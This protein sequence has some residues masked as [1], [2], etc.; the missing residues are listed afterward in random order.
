MPQRSA[1]LWREI[2][3]AQR[4]TPEKIERVVTWA[5]RNQEPYPQGRI[6][7]CVPEFYEYHRAAW[8]RAL[9]THGCL[10]A[11][12][13]FYVQPV[14]Y[15]PCRASLKAGSR[16]CHRHHRAFAAEMVPGRDFPCDV[17]IEEGA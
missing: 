9:T 2:P 16:Y 14:M 7:F 10:G 5:W 1:L 11:A 8:L 12:R 17:V 13:A 6:V 3:E 4:L 15:L